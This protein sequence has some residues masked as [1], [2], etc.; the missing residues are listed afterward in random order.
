[1]PERQS[2]LPLSA[3]A[4]TQ[5]YVESLLRS[6]IGRIRR[7]LP[8][9]EIVQGDC[10]L[11]AACGCGLLYNVLGDRGISYTGVDFAPTAIAKAKELYANAKNA[12]FVCEDLVEFCRSHPNSFDKIL[13]LDFAEH[14]TDEQFIAIFSGLWSALK[15]SG[16]LYIHTPNGMFF[17]ERLKHWGILRQFPEHIA[18]RDLDAYQRLLGGINVLKVTAHFLPHYNVLKLVHPL[19]YV[20]LLGGLFRARL[21][22]VCEK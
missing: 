15:P 6:D 10:V 18:V 7:L 22:F 5:D 13:A 11:D 16:K 17:L 1:M 4:Y 21:L 9:F 3:A 19:S 20:P 14:I 8:Y 2:P 12:T